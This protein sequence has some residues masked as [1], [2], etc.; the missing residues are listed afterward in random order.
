[1]LFRTM[2]AL[3]VAAAGASAALAQGYPTKPVRVIVTFPPGG[4][5]TGF[6]G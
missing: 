2:L 4:T 6:V 3:A 1:M 5:R